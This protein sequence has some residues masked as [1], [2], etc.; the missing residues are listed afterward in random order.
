MV[1]L[2]K[3]DNPLFF[4]F[5]EFLC[6]EC[7]KIFKS[8]INLKYH[9]K[10]HKNE[11]SFSC[12]L[13]FSK[14][15]HKGNLKAHMMSVHSDERPFKC[16]LCGSSFSLSYVLKNHINRVHGRQRKYNCEF[17][18]RAFATS[19]HLRRHRRTHTGEK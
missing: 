17:C 12:T 2:K 1:E 6:K 15:F 14:F 11:R 5:Q 16:E 7:G 9:Q 19:D 13:C 3:Q 4:Q 10:T 8:A 18:Q